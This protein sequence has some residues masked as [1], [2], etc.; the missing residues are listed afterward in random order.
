M[1][2]VG[3]EPI[4][5]RASARSQRLRPLGQ[6]GAAEPISPW[7]Q[8]SRS[9]TAVGFEPKQLALVELES[10][11]FDASGKLSWDLSPS[12]RQG[13]RL[14]AAERQ[15][16]REGRCPRQESNLGRRGYEAVS[17]PLDDVGAGGRYPQKAGREV[18]PRGSP[19][20]RMAM[21]EHGFDPRTFGLRAQRANRC[22]APLAGSSERTDRH[23]N[24]VSN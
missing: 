24:Y 20:L 16:G 12:H 8:R 4:P 15:V 11:P 19:R 10:T 13:R 1:T 5:L 7:P 18:A 3:F 14:D 17:P 2:A 6:T 21:V 22:T 23:A 9:M